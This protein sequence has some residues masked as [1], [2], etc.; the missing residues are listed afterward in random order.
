MEGPPRSNKALT[1]AE[2]GAG[3]TGKGDDERN[4]SAARYPYVKVFDD[5]ME[6]QR[7][8]QQLTDPRTPVT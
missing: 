2:A 7:H 5:L 3:R 6:L 1:P 4:V 8:T